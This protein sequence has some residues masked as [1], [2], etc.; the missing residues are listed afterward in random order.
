MKK[1]LLLAIFVTLV[2]GCGVKRP[3]ALSIQLISTD[4]GVPFSQQDSIAVRAYTLYD[5][6]VDWDITD[7]GAQGVQIIAA[8]GEDFYCA[9]PI[10]TAT[11]YVVNSRSA[12]NTNYQLDSLARLF[13]YDLD[14]FVPGNRYAFCLKAVLYDSVSDTSLPVY[15][16]L[17]R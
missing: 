10:A 14:K 7:T 5:V 6:R 13:P 1:L 15:L 3:Y 12:T 4:S 9:T 2:S 16:D 17:L 11:F 8:H